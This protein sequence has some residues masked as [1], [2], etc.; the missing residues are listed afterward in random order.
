[1]NDFIE[2]RK[3]IIGIL[4]WW[5]VLILLTIVAAAAGYV[6]STRMTRIYQATTTLMV[7]QSIQSIDLNR[8]DMLTS[9][10]LAQT[11]A[12]IARLYPVLQGVIDTL[13]LSTSQA[14]LRDRIQ[15]EL[16]TGT[17]LLRIRVTATS[18]EEAQ[19]IAAEIAQQLI[20]ISPTALL[21]QEKNENQRFVSQRLQSLQTKIEAGQARL[22][23]LDAAMTGSLS[24]EQVQELQTEI[25]ELEQLVA[26][27]E[28]NYTQLLVFAESERSPNY[29][30]VIE[31]AQASPTPIRP[32]TFL[33]TSLAGI[34]GLLLGIALALVLEYLDDTFKN[35][36]DLSQ[37]LGLT[38]LGAIG[39]INGKYYRDKL[40]TVQDLFSP[41]AEAYR[42]VR[43]NIEFM[44]VDQPAKSLVVTSSGPGEGKSVTV[45]N[46]GIVMAQAGLKI[47]IVDADL[48]RPTQ[49][50]IFQVPNL[51]G[52]TDLLRSSEFEVESY[53]RKTDTDN[54]HVI[55]SG[56]LPP[57]PAE[58]LSS[59][60]MKQLITLL[61][62]RADVVIFD[63][64]PTLVVTDATVLSNRVDGTIVVVRANKT[65]QGAAK[66]TIS[67]LRQAG[68]N[69]L[70]SVINQVATK[71]GQYYQTYYASDVRLKQ[72]PIP[73]Q[74]EKK[75]WREKLS[76]FP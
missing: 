34:M 53:M 23:E 30:V 61:S 64:P 68:A 52:L 25:N 63:S 29:L 15:V 36:D 17:Q 24:A 7:G 75:S 9:E 50:Q 39:R 56:T 11:Y 59:Q 12:N 73:V 49:H 70:G 18:P 69:L 58:L 27:W 37:S 67:T 65:R 45:A 19:A 71:Q 41:T 2:L 16:V 32:Q 22:E 74:S 31:P 10:S 40:I 43:S 66:Q 14:A 55:T 35:A 8:T 5:W 44:S 6:V 62:D 1:M 28:N 3:F 20:Q 76:F 13:G 33:N 47:L 46:L 42:M 4:K 57:N 21:S 38:A 72:Q 51:A 26:D 60:R 54:L 48:R